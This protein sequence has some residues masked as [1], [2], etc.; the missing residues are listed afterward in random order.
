MKIS[1]FWVKHAMTAYFYSIT[2]HFVLKDTP[3]KMGSKI[4]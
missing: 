2:E 4:I 3:N 1:L